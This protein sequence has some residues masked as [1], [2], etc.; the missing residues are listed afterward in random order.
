ML[1]KVDHETERDLEL[2]PT[3]GMY[4]GGGGAGGCGDFV[5]LWSICVGGAGPCL[6]ADLLACLG[7]TLG[8]RAALH[9]RSPKWAMRIPGE[10]DKNDGM[11]GTELEL[12]VYL[13]PHL[14]SRCIFMYV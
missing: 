8:L 10:C 11:Q 3:D 2:M 9:L 13:C 12:H 14:R 5:P 4:G 7:P 1:R 6:P